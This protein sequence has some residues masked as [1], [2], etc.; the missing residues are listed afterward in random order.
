[1]NFESNLALFESKKYRNALIDSGDAIAVIDER[2]SYI[3]V[4]KT[5]MQYMGMKKADIMGRVA[6]EVLGAY[7]GEIS[8][9]FRMKTAGCSEQTGHPLGDARLRYSLAHF[10]IA[11]NLL[12]LLRFSN[13]SLGT[14]G[15]TPHF[16]LVGVVQ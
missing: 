16:D 2:Y 7:L 15:V 12:L 8:R 6:P 3:F 13:R 11:F 14:H 10:L 1:M 4:S 9:L 5:L